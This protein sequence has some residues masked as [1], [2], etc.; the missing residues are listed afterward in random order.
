[1]VPAWK[2]AKTLYVLDL[3]G[4]A[5]FA[6]SGALAAGRA[7]L[8]LLGVVVIASVTA[9]GGGTL[10]DLLMNRHPLF[11]I[12]DPRYLV[13]IIATA[14]ATVVYARQFPPPGSALLV[15][16]AFGLALFAI[17]GAEL[18]LEA[19]MPSIVV[20]LMGTMTGV[21]GG[22]IRDVLTAQVPLLL[23]KD[24]YASAAI[25]GIVLYLVLKAAGAKRAVAFMAGLLAV[26]SIRLL[27]IHYSWQLPAFEL[28]G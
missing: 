23:R 9:I 18:A 4:I 7:G 14:L 19:S 10:R 11:W 3:L 17:C 28:H 16:D 15:A 27:A 20:V 2:P 21:G 8:D 13:V 5:V 24:I 6:L 12:R 26:V 1:M 25:A 22:V